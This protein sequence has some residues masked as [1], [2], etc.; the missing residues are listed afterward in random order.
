MWE[1]GENA[2]GSNS[3]SFSNLLGKV[4]RINP[5][6]SIPN[7][8]PFSHHHR[9]ES[10]NLGPGFAQSFTFAFQPGTGRMFINDVGQGTWEEINDGI[11]GSNYG[12]PTTE[13]ATNNPAFRSPLFSYG[14]GTGPTP[15]ARLPVGSFITLRTSNSLRASLGNTSSQ[16][17]AVG[18]FVSLI[19]RLAPPRGFAMGINQPVESK[20]GGRWKPLLPL[21]GSASVFRV[22]FTNG[23]TPS[24][25]Q[26]PAAQTVS[27]DSR[28]RFSSERMGVRHSA[29][30]GNA[31][32]WIFPA[33]P[34]RVL[35]SQPRCSQTT[36]R[37]FRC[38]VSNAFGMAT[39]NE[40]ILTV[41]APPPL[42]VTEDG[43]NVAL[44]F[45]SVTMMRD[46]FPLTNL[47]NFNADTRT[48]VMLFVMNL[49]L[50]PGENSAA[51][52]ARA[53]DAAL[54]VYPLTWNTLARFRALI[55]CLRWWSNSLTARRRGRRFL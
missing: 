24:I 21:I 2:N 18:G 26:H 23:A 33:P 11:A 10:I 29:F 45:D 9:K 6:G 49:D 35:R 20:G 46:P 12:W 40:A 37:K 31:T 7:D 19:Q 50:L 34:H 54:N 48:R 44:A 3:Q 43:T 14:H 27:Q 8:N 36:V 41:N 55:G 15:D 38:I 47:F 30:N 13:G 17:F 32:W 25:T 53:E 16:I 1:V 51:V 22:R 5:D 28:Q 4:L 39:S 42:I 52:T